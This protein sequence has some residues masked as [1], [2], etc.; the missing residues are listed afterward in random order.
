[1]IFF[2]EKNES[3]L[4]K[5]LIIVSLL[6]ALFL[7]V[8]T[9]K[10][11][12]HFH[13]IILIIFVSIYILRLVLTLFR[14]IQR[15]L[16]WLETLITSVLMS[17]ILY[18]L[19]NTGKASPRSFGTYD[20]FGILLYVIGSFVN[21]YSEYLRYIWKSNQSNKGHIYRYGL[22]KYSMHINYFGD[23]L[24]FYGLSILTGRLWTL[25]IPTG[26]LLNFVIFIIPSL[27]NYLAKKYGD[28]FV[29]YSKTTKKLIPYI[30]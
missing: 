27:D 4:Q 2:N 7:S 9:N 30:Y 13:Q 3:I 18:T 19:V 5:T 8:F 22:F 6:I 1:M 10:Y 21:T 25:I 11:P 24:L 16:V 12:L 14:F 15:K 20:L 23:V 17:I 28:E 29:E 26:M